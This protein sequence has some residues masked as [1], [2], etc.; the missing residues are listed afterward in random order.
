[1]VELVLSL[2]SDFPHYHILICKIHTQIW[3]VLLAIGQAG[4][5]TKLML[6]KSFSVPDI[7]ESMIYNKLF[8]LQIQTLG[9]IVQIFSLF[10]AVSYLTAPHCHFAS[11]DCQA[12]IFFFQF[13]WK[14]ECLRKGLLGFS[15]KAHE[16]SV[17]MDYIFVPNIWLKGVL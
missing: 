11:L 6:T 15:Y 8:P 17:I 14:T 3:K 12:F 7:C 2:A 1:M 5:Q 10:S 4:R 13:V 9:Y 16:I